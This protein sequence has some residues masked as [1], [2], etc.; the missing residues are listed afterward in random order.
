MGLNALLHRTVGAGERLRAHHGERES[1][2]GRRKLPLEPVG[3]W[4][5][6]VPQRPPRQ[7][8]PRFE[9]WDQSSAR[10]HLGRKLVL[11]MLPVSG[12][13]RRPDPRPGHHQLADAVVVVTLKP[14]VTE[15]MGKFPKYSKFADANP[16]RYTIAG[17]DLIESAEEARKA[18]GMAEEIRWNVRNEKD[19]T[20]Q[21]VPSCLI[22]GG[23]TSPTPRTRSWAY[24]IPRYRQYQILVD[25]AERSVGRAPGRLEENA[26]TW[27][28]NGVG[29]IF[30]SARSKAPTAV[31]VGLC[32][33]STRRPLMNRRQGPKRCRKA[34]RSAA[35]I[36]KRWRRRRARTT[37][38][39]VS[40]FGFG[41]FPMGSGETSFKVTRFG[42]SRH[43]QRQQEITSLPPSPPFRS[44]RPALCGPRAWAAM[45]AASST[46]RAPSWRR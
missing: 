42:G 28:R 35:T 7:L 19:R 2:R 5:H 26:P 39:S 18:R 29:S 44:T 15:T 3:V 25:T 11:S 12:G 37:D 43:L 27:S 14:L 24:Q 38:L 31:S 21:D 34:R 33:R 4:K 32:S 22:W 8:R 17:S 23:G 13:R 41:R 40:W 45:P 30:S 6:D 10:N 9:I 16:Q 1:G 46:R 36:R 20:T